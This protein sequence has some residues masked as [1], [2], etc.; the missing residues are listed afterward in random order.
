MG[1][2]STID[3][4]RFSFLPVK[5][6][7]LLLITLSVSS[8]SG[9][10]ATLSDH[11]S[12]PACDALKMLGESLQKSNSMCVNSMPKTECTTA[13][14]EVIKT[15]LDGI[16]VDQVCLEDQGREGSGKLFFADFSKWYGTTT[17]TAAPT[18]SG[19]TT[20]GPTTAGPTTAGPT[21]AAPTTAAPTTAAPT[22]AAP[23]TAAP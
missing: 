5:M 8:L 4:R 2:I 6:I 11:S 19:P 7:P 12:K 21:T 15:C 23:T 18:T 14:L 16:K 9:H 1:V 13:S 20:A 22:T 10:P 17:T 3:R